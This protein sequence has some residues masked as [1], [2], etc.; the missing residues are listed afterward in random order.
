MDKIAK[1]WIYFILNRLSLVSYKLNFAKISFF[2]VLFTIYSC[3]TTQSVVVGDNYLARMKSDVKFLSS[4]ELEGRETGTEGEIKAAAY[5]EERFI[6]LG[7]K[8]IF[9]SNNSFYQFFE[10]T[11]RSNPHGAVPEPT[12][13]VIMGRNVGGFL[14]KNAKSTIII[15]AHYDHLGYGGEGSLYVGE[16][17]IHNGADDNASGVAIMLAMAEI[18]KDKDLN[19][20]VLFLAFS[21]EEK[22]LWGS[23]F[24]VDNSPLTLSDINYMIN[25][26]MVGRLNDE[27]KLALYG[28]GTSPAWE[29]AFKKVNNQGFSFTKQESGVGPSDH[30]S[31]YFEDIPVLMF[32]TGQHE[33]Y[34]RP[35]DDFEKINFSGMVDITSYLA[36]LVLAIDKM[37]KMLF[38]KTKDESQDAPDFKVT[39]GVIPDYL[40][41]GKGMR[42]D[43]VR[44]DRPA[45]NAGLKKGDVVVKMGDLEIVDMQSY[46]KAL[47]V[48][49]PGETITITIVR[50]EDMMMEKPLTF[51]KKK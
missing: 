30:T 3:K 14:D 15:G 9:H 6:D 8:G 42:I 22:G 16:P 43:G 23:N 34:H 33:D 44:E 4:D 40:F 2:I 29:K 47:S 31:F 5:I 49:E 25:L 48:F 50:E 37:P 12:D 26:D 51:L 36:N 32:F 27:K 18:L 45:F 20:N 39:L 19:Y 17:A 38:T 24:F 13:P 41:D 21:G 28:T 11:I 35:S 7:L 1:N 10:K 46:M